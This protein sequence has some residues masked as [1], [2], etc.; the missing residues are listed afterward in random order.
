MALVRSLSFLDG[1]RRSAM[2][3]TR[4]CISITSSAADIGEFSLLSVERSWGFG[5][6]SIRCLASL[7]TSET[8]WIGKAREMT[9]ISKELYERLV[10]EG[11]QG[12]G[13]NQGNAGMKDRESAG[14]R[15]IP[16]FAATSRG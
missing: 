5:D 12:T 6:T 9:R 15:S 1:D 10:R 2:K 4:P 14:K 16:E 11:V 13:A 3:L 7:E 8:E